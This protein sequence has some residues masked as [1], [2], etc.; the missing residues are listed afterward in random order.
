MHSVAYRYIV[1]VI[2]AVAMTIPACSQGPPTIQDALELV[3]AEKLSELD[4]MLKS[5]PELANAK[6][7]NGTPLVSLAFEGLRPFCSRAVE[8]VLRNGGD[9]NLQDK[10]GLTPLH[11]LAMVGKNASIQDYTTVGDVGVL[12]VRMGARE[13]RKNNAGQTPEE[14][15]KAI[16]SQAALSFYALLRDERASK[17]RDEPTY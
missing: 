6:D 4:A 14:Y 5:H 11:R 3:R 7:A 10:D 17:P 8:I 16:K 2:I 13:D 12:L 15:A 9:P 1:V